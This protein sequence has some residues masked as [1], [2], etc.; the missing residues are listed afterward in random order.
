MPVTKRIVC[1]ANSRK[2]N[3]RCIAGREL[4]GSQ[5]A[6]WIRPVSDRP[7]HAVSKDERQY[8]DGSD[9]SALD[10]VDVPVLRSAPSM[11]QQENWLIDPDYY[12]EKVGQIGWDDLPALA[13]PVAPLW[14]DGHSTFKGRNN[15]IPLTLTGPLK[16][17]LL[18]LHVTE[19]GL[20]VH[21][22]G[23]AFDDPR[24]RVQARFEHAD[25]KYALR[26]T[27]PIYE[28]RFLAKPNGD[29]ALGECYLTVSLGE[30]YKGD[31][32][33]L[34]ATIIERATT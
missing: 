11:F 20:R 19:V 15:K 18:L 22:P 14:I 25:T 30:P 16:S 33:K 24:R 2:P 10:V 4:I 8:A 13:D 32:Y 7:G 28:R 9:P 31:A 26:V 5:P 3:G 34:V 27:D 1:L 23:E 17:S 29:Y 21:A 6:G 12:W